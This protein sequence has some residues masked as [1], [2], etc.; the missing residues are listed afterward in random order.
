MTTPYV[1]SGPYCYANSVA[2]MMG[3]DAPSTAVIEFATGSAFGMQLVG[4][5]LPFFDPYGWTPQAGVDAALAAAGWTATTHSGGDAGDALSRLRTHLATAPVFIGPVEMGHLRHQPGMTG[6][7]GADHFLVA[8]EVSDDHVLVHDPQG[9]PYATV[10]LDAFMAAWRAE[11]V[12]YGAPFTMRTD[13]LR[14]REAAES[15]IIEAAIAVGV[16]WLSMSTAHDMPPGSCGNAEAAGRLAELIA[17]GCPDELRD[18]LVHFAV[19]VGA[20]R[21]DDAAT[22]LSRGGYAGAARV[23][24]SQARLIGALQYPLVAGDD[25]TVSAVLRSL[26][27]TY[28]ELRAAMTSRR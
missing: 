25:T 15:E 24:R 23:L 27:A 16:D 18:H 11:T 2:M 14:V 6:P 9:Y 7:I 3:K 8:L 5:T 10:P 1:G 4:G 22:V 21:A 28:G 26:A 12:E 13:F 19:Q 20:R 17:A